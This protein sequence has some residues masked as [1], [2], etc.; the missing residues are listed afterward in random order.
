MNPTHAAESVED[1]Q[2]RAAR[3]G[4]LHHRLLGDRGPLLEQV[5]QAAELY[6]LADELLGEVGERLVVGQQLIVAL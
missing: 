4:R 2:R 5:G 1:D 6:L 3:P